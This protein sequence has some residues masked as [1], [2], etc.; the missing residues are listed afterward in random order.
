MAEENAFPWYYTFWVNW[1]FL[2]SFPW[3]YTLNFN[4]GTWP[5]HYLSSVCLSVKNAISRYL[6]YIVCLS[7]FLWIVRIMGGCAHG[8]CGGT[9][10]T[11][12]HDVIWSSEEENLSS[13]KLFEIIMT[14]IFGHNQACRYCLPLH[15]QF[16][17]G[18]HRKY[19]RLKIVHVFN[20]TYEIL[21]RNTYDH[22]NVHAI[23]QM[24]RNTQVMKWSKFAPQGSAL[25]CWV[26]TAWHMTTWWVLT[27]T[28]FLS[29]VC[30]QHRYS[31]YPCF[32]LL[33]FHQMPGSKVG[34]MPAMT[35]PSTFW[36]HSCIIYCFASKRYWSS[37]EPPGTS[38]VFRESSSN[39]PSV[40]GLTLC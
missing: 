22:I 31:W 30:C 2:P 12:R 32:Q 28:R 25:L 5:T 18:Q 24:V 19:Q 6:L 8:L 37:Q 27:S 1:P 4:I 14:L 7:S 10:I 16:T 11:S 26:A 33:R 40:S 34:T 3:Y 23:I 21:N 29:L 39:L 13:S 9:L 15:L 20:L 35:W 17:C 36:R 38:Q